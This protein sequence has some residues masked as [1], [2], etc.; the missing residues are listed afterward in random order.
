LEDE[1]LAINDDG[2]T[3]VVTA[4]VAGYDRKAPRKDIDDLAFALIAPLRAYDNRSPASAQIRTPRIEFAAAPAA[5]RVAH[6][7]RPRYLRRKKWK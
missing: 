4:C 2:M 7:C 3:S 1:L 5:L 6:T